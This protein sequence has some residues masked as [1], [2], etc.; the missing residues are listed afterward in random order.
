MPCLERKESGGRGLDKSG[1][2]ATESR[3][4]PFCDHVLRQ[5]TA[6]REEDW[7]ARHP[8]GKYSHTS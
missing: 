7:G 6:K 3:E 1:D 5:T 4:K 2:K 8:K